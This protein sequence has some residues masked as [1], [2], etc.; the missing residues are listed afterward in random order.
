MMPYA[1]NTVQQQQQY[2]SIALVDDTMEIG[3]WFERWQIIQRNLVDYYDTE[4]AHPIIL[5]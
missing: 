1:G 2:N 5:L 4:R 3:Y